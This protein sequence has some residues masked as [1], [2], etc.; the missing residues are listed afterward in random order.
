[1]LSAGKEGEIGMAMIGGNPEAEVLAREWM[2]VFPDRFYLEIQRTNRPNDEEQLHG[3]V[4]LADKL[5]APLVATNDV[6]F[7]K[8]EDFAAHETRVC[9]GEGRALDDPRR[10]K[11]YSDQQYLKSAEEMAELFSDIPDAIENTVEIAKRCNIEVKLGKHF[12]PNFPI[13]G[14]TIDEYFR[15]VSFDGLEERLGAAAQ[16]HHRRLR[17]QAPGL[18]RPAEVRAGHHHPDGLPRL[19]PDR[20][21]LYP[22]GQEQR[23]AGGP[24]PGS[25]AGSLV[26]YVLKITDLDPLEYDLLFE[27]FLNP[28]RVSMPDF[29][30]DFCMDG[31]DRVIDYVAELRPRSRQPD[32][33]LRHHGA[34]AVVRDVGR[35]LDLPSACATGC[36]S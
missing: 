28:E 12:L 21:G 7:I 6:R 36:P 23:R 1:M 15:K 19:L 32:R 35:V 24:G 16:G 33:H 5:G 9:I 13:P 3:A 20:D 34:K 2:A 17:G 29:D 4:A 18:R 26:A 31:R 22:V 27:R 11:N 14:M 10:S 8:Q 30:V 25:G